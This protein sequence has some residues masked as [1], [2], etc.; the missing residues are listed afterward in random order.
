MAVIDH[1][2]RLSR[3][4]AALVGSKRPPEEVARRVATRKRNHPP[5]RPLCHPD[6]KYHARGMCR[7]CY[8]SGRSV[9]Y[10]RAYAQ[11][12]RPR[13]R[14][15][16]LRRTFGLTLGQY[17]EMRD[18]QG[19]RCAI[20]GTIPK[21]ALDVDHDHATGRIRGLLCS[22]CNTAIGLLKDDPERMTAAAT[23][24]LKH[25]RSEAA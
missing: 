6:R 18:Q 15:A 19:G 9:A 13:A 14:E 7:S 8:G 24:I 25:D 16:E 11:A 3:V 4:R 5:Q 23:Y 17:E 2:Y 10:H 20:C 22:N 12:N 21:R 1:T